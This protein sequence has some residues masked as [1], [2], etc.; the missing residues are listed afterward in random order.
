[1]SWPRQAKSRSSA[2]F[3]HPQ[4]QFGRPGRCPW[5]AGEEFAHS[6]RSPCQCAGRRGQD[7]GYAAEQ[8]A[9]G[10]AD[11]GSARWV[12]MGL[13]YPQDRRLVQKDHGK[14]HWAFKRP[15]DPPAP[16]VKDTSWPRSDLDR[17]ILARLEEKNLKPAAA[18]GSPRPDPPCNF[19][20]DG[21]AA[22]AGGGGH[23]L[24]WT[25]PPM[26]SPG[27]WIGYW[28]VRI[29]ANTGAGTG[30]MWLAMPIPMGWM[31]TWLSATPGVFAI[32]SWRHST[33]TSRM[34]SCCSNNLRAICCREVLNSGAIVCIATGFLAL[35]PKVLAEVDE[36]RW[37]SDI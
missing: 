27:S 26:P 34:T 37:R 18:C 3:A 33:R 25:P 6:G 14:S 8:E 17:F 15:V 32:T 20:P 23:P 21:I 36:R 30:S 35:G 2:G 22:H 13:P 7:S 24:S 31:K 19:R 28:P 5:S 16:A 11:C 29:T 1:M 9:L 4:G 10:S 12:Q